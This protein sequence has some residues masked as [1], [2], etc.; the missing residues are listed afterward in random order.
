MITLVTQ[1]H[2]AQQLL[3]NLP[4]VGIAVLG[5]VLH[6]VHVALGKSALKAVQRRLEIVV[7]AP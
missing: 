4:T 5:I 1:Q 6:S 7:L 2:L 3:A